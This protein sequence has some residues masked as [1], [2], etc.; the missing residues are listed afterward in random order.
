MAAPDTLNSFL[1]IFSGAAVIA[2]AA[3]FTRQPMLIA[4]I[5]LGLV[6]GPH[7]VSLIQ[8]TGELQNIAEIGIIFLLFLVGLD[9][10]P[11]KLKNLLEKSLLTALGTSIIFFVAT[12]GIMLLAGFQPLEAFV[13]GLAMTFSSTILGIKLLP[14]TALHHRHIGELVISLL[15]IQDLLAIFAILILGHLGTQQASEPLDL[16][17]I[18]LGLP[19]LILGAYQVM[20]RLIVPLIARFDDF[21]EYVFLLA[22]GWCLACAEVAHLMGLSYEIGGFIAGVALATNPI[23][24]YIAEHLKP[25]RDFF[26]IIFFFTVGAALNIS[27]LQVAWL[28]ALALAL[29]LVMLKPW[30]FYWLLK[31]QGEEPETAKEV[32]FRLGQGSEF[33]LMLSYIAISGGLIGDSAALV[34]QGATVLTLVLSSYWVVSRY[35][36]PIAARPELRRD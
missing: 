22:I 19:V 3:L 2:T 36:S 4:Y 16:V 11:A 12:G 8:D 9:L 26:L 23:A 17:L 15:L 24:K 14:T 20:Q 21:H 29:T 1:I 7:G 32:G 13:A 5:L 18:I 30:T 6:V 34:I 28:P 35:P 31:G 27:L 25:L 10:P 33:S